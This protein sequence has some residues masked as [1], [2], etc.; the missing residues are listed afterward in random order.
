MLEQIH[1]I[2][3]KDKYAEDLK[4]LAHLALEGVGID[5]DKYST[6]GEGL[7]PD[8]IKRVYTGRSKFWLAVKG[9]RLV[10]CV[11]LNEVEDEPKTAELKRMFVMPNLQRMGIGKDLLGTLVSFARNNGYERIVLGTDRQMEKAHRFYEKRMASRRRANTAWSCI[12][13]WL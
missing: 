8:Y 2:D 10:G 7:D 11:G 3:F 6:V 12:M 5:Y 13:K 9:D 4:T 1:V